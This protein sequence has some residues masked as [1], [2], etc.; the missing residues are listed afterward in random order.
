MKNKQLVLRKVPKPTDIVTITCYNKTEKMERKKAI[1]F[2]WEGVC[3]CDGHERSRYL[4]IVQQLK[5]GQ[6]TATDEGV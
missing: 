4:A 3:A 2:Y 5:A 6:M 1:D